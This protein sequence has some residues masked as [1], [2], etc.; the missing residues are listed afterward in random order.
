MNVKQ[1]K[2]KFD[3][4]CSKTLQCVAGEMALQLQD[5]APNQ[6]ELQYVSDDDE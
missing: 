3:A 2:K 1:C 6:K 4:T 5:K